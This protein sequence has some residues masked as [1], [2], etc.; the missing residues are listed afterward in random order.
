[1]AEQKEDGNPINTLEGLIYDVKERV[2][3]QEYIDLMKALAVLKK[4]RDN[5]V[6]MKPGWI[7]H[8]ITY[9]ELKKGRDGD[10]DIS[11]TYDLKTCM[12]WID[13]D[14][15]E[16]YWIGMSFRIRQDCLFVF[17]GCGEGTK[18]TICETGFR[19]REYED[20]DRGNRIQY[21]HAPSLILA[22]IKRWEK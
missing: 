18:E 17:E 22:S 19:I 8:Q 10:G 12:V 7:L 13:P 2:K 21:V 14:K 20:S 3:N 4:E 1:M 15:I 11:L 5:S 16:D 6:I 9:F